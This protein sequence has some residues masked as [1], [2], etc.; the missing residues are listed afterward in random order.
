MQTPA[1]LAERGFCL[2][3][4]NDNDLPWLCELYASTR[5]EEMAP[6]PWPKDAKRRFLDQ[7]FALQHRHYLTHYSN[8]DYSNTDYLVI[9]HAQGGPAGRYYLQRAADQ[10]LLVDISVFPALRGNG[11][12]SALIGQS[13]RDA[14]AVGRGMRLHVHLANHAAQRLYTRLGFRAQAPA[15]AY[16]AMHWMPATH[17]QHG[18]PGHG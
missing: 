6:V 4:A 11:I 1:I 16:L 18:R 2:R 3:A 10:H 9:E 8:T 14:A 5:A 12:G 15:G 7:Q 17:S 13:Q